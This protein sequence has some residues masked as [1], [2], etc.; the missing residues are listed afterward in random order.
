VIL[1][2]SNS[3]KRG[4][5]GAFIFATIEQRTVSADTRKTLLQYRLDKTTKNDYKQL[6]SCRKTHTDSPE[7]MKFKI[8][9]PF[10]SFIISWNHNTNLTPMQNLRR[11]WYYALR[12]PGYYALWCLIVFLFLRV[13]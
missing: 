6:S 4:S 7:M 1:A 13:I 8:L 12:D 3:L 10:Y 9:P 11:D 2:R 5:K